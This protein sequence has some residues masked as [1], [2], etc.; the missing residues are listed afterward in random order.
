MVEWSEGGGVLKEGESQS[1]PPSPI[2][3]PP[4]LS[5]LFVMITIR[6]GAI[7]CG[8]EE[9]GEDVLDP[10]PHPRHRGRVEKGRG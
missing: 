5:K 6:V 7:H 2:H 10:G 8:R 4:P 9:G 3:P 1:Q